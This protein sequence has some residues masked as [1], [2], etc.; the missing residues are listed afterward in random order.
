MVISAYVK[1]KRMWGIYRPLVLRIGRLVLV[2]GFLTSCSL[3]LPNQ[4]PPTSVLTDQADIY[5][6]QTAGAL[7][8]AGP[9]DTPTATVTVDLPTPTIELTNSIIIVT[10]LGG[11][12]DVSIQVTE[13]S[14]TFTPFGDQDVLSCAAVVEQCRT[15]LSLIQGTT[16]T[17]YGMVTVVDTGDL[18][19]C[20]DPLYTERWSGFVRCYRMM[21]YKVGVH[22]Y[23]TYYSAE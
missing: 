7:P 11:E 9:T 17:V 8:T 15:W 19:V 18:F 22:T 16:I 21:A 2:L 4:N 1:G 23:G 6:S 12:P 10:P 14:G 3:P 20:I 13:V 5:A